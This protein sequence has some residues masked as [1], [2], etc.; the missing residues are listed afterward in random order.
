MTTIV[1]AFHDHD[2]SALTA[3]FNAITEFG[4]EKTHESLVWRQTNFLFAHFW[5][6]SSEPQL[7][8]RIIVVG[9]HHWPGDPFDG[10][11]HNEFIS[12]RESLNSRPLVV[13]LDGATI[14][15]FLFPAI[16]PSDPRIEFCNVINVHSA[17]ARLPQAL[18]EKLG[19]REITSE[20]KMAEAILIQTEWG[21]GLLLDASPS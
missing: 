18:A 13:R 20:T 7:D 21:A 12:N 15:D 5:R 14:S 16:V 6:S 11:W 9:A 19:L 1:F 10:D 2:R 8:F 3:G 17:P 4:Y